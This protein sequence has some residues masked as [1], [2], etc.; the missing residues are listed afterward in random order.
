M[1]AKI[2]LLESKQGAVA[3]LSHSQDN[4]TKWEEIKSKI[5][6]V[7]TIHE[8]DF[9]A[10]SSNLSKLK[11]KATIHRSTVYDHDTRLTQLEL[12]NV[13]CISNNTII[14]DNGT[15]MHRLEADNVDNDN[16]FRAKFETNFLAL[17]NNITELKNEMATHESSVLDHSTRLTQLELDNADCT[18]NETIIQGYDIRIV[19]LEE[20]TVAIRQ[21]IQ[22]LGVKT[23]QL[24]LVMSGQ[25]T[26][27]IYRH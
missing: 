25:G 24:E 21:A 12:D 14:Q 3:N 23:T 19:Q 5:A 16:A 15:R 17:S 6:D 4:E 7:Q 18:C 26:E 9:L 8:T 20:D 1:Q 13:E 11:E 2:N 22:A 27:K 10:L